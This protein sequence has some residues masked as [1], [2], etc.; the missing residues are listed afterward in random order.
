MTHK[1]A[2]HCGAFFMV[3]DVPLSLF[4]FDEGVGERNKWTFT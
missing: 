2:P 1:K 4:V 3:N